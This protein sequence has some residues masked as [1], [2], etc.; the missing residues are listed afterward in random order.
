MK[1]IKRVSREEL[2]STDMPVE[3]PAVSIA[4]TGRATPAVYRFVTEA[5][6]D[7]FVASIEAREVLSA[8]KDLL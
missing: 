4:P 7:A 6:R 8:W 1:T 5:D 2:L 3:L